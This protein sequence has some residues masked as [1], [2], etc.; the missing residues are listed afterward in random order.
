[1]RALAVSGQDPDRA[2]DAAWRLA[3]GRPATPDEQVRAR[4][5]IRDRGLAHVCWVLLNSTE[6]V[7]VR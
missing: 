5:A 6:F 7:Y 3:L 4:A 2:V 1:D